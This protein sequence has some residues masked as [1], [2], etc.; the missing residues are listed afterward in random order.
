MLGIKEFFKNIQNK[1]TQELFVR[2]VVQEAIKVSTGIP[3]PIQTI[4]R[5]GGVVSLKGANS[6]LKST[7]FIKKN[8]IIAYI[9]DHQSIQEITDIR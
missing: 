7:V 5:A 4:Q 8:T 9:N 2:S 3:I 1:H 6:A